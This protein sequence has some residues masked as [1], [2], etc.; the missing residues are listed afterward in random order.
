MNIICHYFS[1]VHR[2]FVFSASK[3]SFDITD[4]IISC[5]SNRII[6]VTCIIWFCSTTGESTFTC[7]K[8]S[9][10][11]D[12]FWYAATSSTRMCDPFGQFW[13]V[14]S[15]RWNV[16]FTVLV[17]VWLTKK[18]GLLPGRVH[19]PLEV[20]WNVCIREYTST[21]MVLNAFLML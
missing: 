20:L 2:L 4:Q 18:L 1:L 19:Q 7:T 12:V 17:Y 11:T 5:E 21:F 16:D 3:S 6:I 10:H 14:H 9:H 15:F 13:S 8:F